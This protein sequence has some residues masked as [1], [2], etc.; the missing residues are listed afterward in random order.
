[1]HKLK[2]QGAKSTDVCNVVEMHQKRRRVGG[3]YAIS[4][5]EQH[6]TII[7]WRRCVQMGVY[8]TFLIFFFVHVYKFAL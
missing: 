7:K 5:V 2:G 3:G 8:A 4:Q 1:M 6:V